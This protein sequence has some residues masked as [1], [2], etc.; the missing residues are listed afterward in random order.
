MHWQFETTGLHTY[1]NDLEYETKNRSS[2]ACGEVTD[3]APRNP[4]SQRLG[5]DSSAPRR[6]L[7]C[8]LGEGCAK[9]GCLRRF[10]PSARRPR[11]QVQYASMGR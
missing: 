8:G 10:D 5:K 4:A 7:G 1:E 11:H 9:Q 2:A 6:S 3:E